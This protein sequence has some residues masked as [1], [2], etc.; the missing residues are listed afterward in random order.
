VV[1]VLQASPLAYVIEAGSLPLSAGDR[2][3]GLR[4]G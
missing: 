2:G 4:A 3:L 1:S